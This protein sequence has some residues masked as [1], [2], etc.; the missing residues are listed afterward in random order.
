MAGAQQAGEVEAALGGG[1]G[2]GGE[3]RVADLGAEAVLGLVARPGVVHRDPGAAREPGTQHVARFVAET[4]LPLDQQA[5]HLA[6]GNI[7]AERAQQPH[8]ARDR[9]LSLMMERQHEAAELRPEMALKALRQRRRYHLA[10]RS[11]PA[12]AAEFNDVW[13]HHEVLHHEAGV[14]FEARACR[15]CGH[16]DL[17]FL[18]DRQLRARAAASAPLL[19]CT[20][21]SL[22]RQ[23][24]SDRL[25][26]PCR[27]ACCSA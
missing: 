7:D 8:R 12:L 6:L 21:S 10:V 5:D 22:H 25:P 26:A 11:L 1:G 2:E 9:G 15:R 4:V 3:V 24:A 18:I 17:A 27:S 16:L 20:A 23:A 13:T 19:P 14:A